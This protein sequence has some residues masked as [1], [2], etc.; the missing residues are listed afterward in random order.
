MYNGHEYQY[1]CMT[2]CGACC[3][4][5]EDED[6]KEQQRLSMMSPSKLVLQTPGFKSGTAVSLS[7]SLSCSF[8]VAP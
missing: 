4:G 1:I 6:E 8:I 2:G 7:S 3:H 5:V